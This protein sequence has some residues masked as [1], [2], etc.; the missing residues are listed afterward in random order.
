MYVIQRTD[1]KQPRWVSKSGSA[2]S[3]TGKLQ[4][5]RTFTTRPIAQA[6]TCTGNEEVVS[7]VEVMP[8]P[9]R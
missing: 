9:T 7:V 4:D 8:A 5:A 1:T 2:H 6:N 3:Y